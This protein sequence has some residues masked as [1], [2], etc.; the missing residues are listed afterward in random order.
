MVELVGLGSD[1]DGGLLVGRTAELT[2]LVAGLNAARLGQGGI[3]GIKGD[4][5]LGKSRLVAALVPLAAELGMGVVRGSALTFGDRAYGALQELL[6]ALLGIE[7]GAEPH[8]QRAR[9]AA[10]FG[11]IGLGETERLH[12]AH[13]LDLEATVC[14]FGQLEGTAVRWNDMGA[15]RACVLAAARRR[16]LLL[17]LDDMHVA[18]GLTRESIEY[19]A[20]E[21]GVSC[22]FVVV[23]YRRG[24]T[25]PPYARELVLQGLS[26]EAVAELCRHQLGTVD[27]G[28]RFLDE[29]TD[30]AMG[31]PLFADQ[32]VR[33]VRESGGPVEPLPESLDMLVER[34][35]ELLPP[36][37]RAVLE[38]AALMG[39][40][41][42]AELLRAVVSEEGWSQ[43]PALSER[44]LLVADGPLWLRAPSPLV[45]DVVRVVTPRARQ[46][47]V[48]G[49]VAACMEARGIGVADPEA[50]AIQWDRA[51]QRPRSAPYYLE[52]A[53]RAT[54]RHAYWEAE[55]LYRAFLSQGAPGVERAEAL[56]ELGVVQNR[57]GWRAEA[58]ESFQL[59]LR[60]AQ[61]S[62]LR[63]LEARGM[64]ELA[65]LSRLTGRS[66]EAA[67][68]LDEAL[69][70]HRELGD[71]RGEALVRDH[72]ATLQKQRG[73]MHEA[74]E[75]YAQA[76]AIHRELGNENGEAGILGSL[77]ALDHDQ[78]HLE[79]ARE[80]ALRA[81]ALHRA[82]G[83]RR[84]EGTVLG[85]IASLA[86]ERG[87]MEEARDLYEAAI[88]IHREVGDRRRMAINLFNLA[89]L[90]GEQ[91][92]LDGAVALAEQSLR[93]HREVGN[94]W[95][96]GATL[97]YLAAIAHEQGHLERA[98]QMYEDA[99]GVLREVEYWPFLAVNLGYVA[100]LDHHEGRLDESER[101]FREALDLHRQTGDRRG[102]SLTLAKM[103]AL[104]RARGR[105]EDSLASLTEAVRLAQDV[106]DR[107]AQAIAKVQ[108]AATR[109][110]AGADG[111]G[112][113]VLLSDAMALL[114]SVGDRLE[115]ARCACEQ[116]HVALLLGRSADA[117]LERARRVAADLALR[118]EA[119]LSAA[120]AGLERAVAVR[121]QGGLLW[122]GEAAADASDRTE[123][124]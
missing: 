93:M 73:V 124:S 46:R 81:L 29:V 101:R 116:G 113:L 45:R 36:C 103:G 84:S 48:H 53:R 18:D 98:R 16:P 83:D 58:R 111:S 5:G 20:R 66:D 51:G 24:Y 10:A 60:D 94:R 39:T 70:L 22:C 12:L 91:G 67:T 63:T 13:V 104:E 86:R 42:E 74:R 119:P 96:E 97:G 120:V 2:E 95:S 76:L 23:L 54:R 56:L 50:L 47:E 85:N 38:T 87:E 122:R 109:R 37:A 27:A 21:V 78:G 89:L 72:L 26:N 71:R 80:L 115:M 62:G 77:A 30:L 88:A 110:H 75:H 69:A 57:C 11:E 8:A 106:G 43:L 79:S 44:G 19:L 65:A 28:P 123:T 61:V 112:L 1:S 33:L 35:I 114:S 25:P 82:A 17:V 14:P 7:R 100:E 55:R 102:E 31:S 34:R 92:R 32:A 41:F 4:A 105:L 3:V 9:L 117:E 121:R 108:L 64:L 118:E 68:L 6:V 15:L 99:I 107:R 40:C 52:A 49:R 59:A 90:H